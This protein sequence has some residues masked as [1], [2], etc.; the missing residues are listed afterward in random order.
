MSRTDDK[1]ND[2]LPLARCPGPTWQDLLDAGLITHIQ[3]NEMGVVAGVH[4]LERAGA[5]INGAPPNHHFGALG[6][7]CFGDA[8]TDAPCTACNG[9]N[10]ALQLHRFSYARL[11]NV[12]GSSSMVR[13][14][15]LGT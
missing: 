8:P 6:Q 12:I 13:C 9:G 10:F 5:F 2:D 7:K 4:F 14:T 1:L 15:M 11:V 3:G